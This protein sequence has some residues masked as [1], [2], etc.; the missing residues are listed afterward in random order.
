ME[1]LLNLQLTKQLDKII[2][3][4]NHSKVL[5]LIEK[6]ESGEFGKSGQYSFYC[7]NC[8]GAWMSDS[9]DEVSLFEKMHKTLG[10]SFEWITPDYSEHKNPK[11]RNP[12]VIIPRL[13]RTLQY[14]LA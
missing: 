5:D 12:K 7:K 1:N 9:K 14:K 2:T 8:G 3:P 6:I 10:C 4:E 13:R 11:K